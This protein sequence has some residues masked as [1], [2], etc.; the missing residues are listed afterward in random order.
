MFEWMNKL[1]GNRSD[2]ASE[3]VVREDPDTLRPGTGPILKWQYIIEPDLDVPSTAVAHGFALYRPHDPLVDHLGMKIKHLT[4][5]RAVYSDRPAL[6]PPPWL[7]ALKAARA[8]IDSGA[9]AVEKVEK[10]NEVH[11]TFGA[12]F[13]QLRQYSPLG[14][15]PAGEQWLSLVFLMDGL[16]RADFFVGDGMR[17]PEDALKYDLK[18]VRKHVRY[19]PKR[20]QEFLDYQEKVRRGEAR[21]A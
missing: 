16:P 13:E 18:R 10:I 17:E 5:W 4:W 3:Q 14:Q 2:Q 9:S 21:R 12:S 19:S 15:R 11:R 8:A 1:L 6:R 20:A 7:P